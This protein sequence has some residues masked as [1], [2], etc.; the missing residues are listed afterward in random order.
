M[1]TTFTVLNSIGWLILIA[2]WVTP[3]I[4]KDE[5]DKYY[6]GAVLAAVAC[7]IFVSALIVQLM[8]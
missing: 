6:V 8:K 3:R 4:V 5:L 2:S 1:V 7:G